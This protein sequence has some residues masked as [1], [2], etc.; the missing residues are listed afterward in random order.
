MMIEESRAYRYAKWCIGRNNRNVGRYVKRQA[1][2]WLKIAD[3]KHKS[4]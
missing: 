4:A 2:R 3:G 1:K